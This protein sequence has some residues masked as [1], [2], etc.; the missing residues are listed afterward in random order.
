MDN[1]MLEVFWSYNGS[2]TI[3]IPSDKVEDFK[4]NTTRYL[5]EPLVSE[6]EGYYRTDFEKLVEDGY[7]GSFVGKNTS[8][9]GD[10]EGIEE[11]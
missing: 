4:N 9:D 7:S 1:T 3:S 10:I 6:N 5:N 11:V 8:W 2:V